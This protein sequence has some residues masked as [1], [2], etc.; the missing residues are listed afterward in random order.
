MAASG[1]SASASGLNGNKGLEGGWVE[2]VEVASDNDLH[3]K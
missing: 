2:Y 1:P 3:G